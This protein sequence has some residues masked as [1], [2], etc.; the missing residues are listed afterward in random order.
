MSPEITEVFI[1]AAAV[2]KTFAQH[3]IHGLVGT[4]KPVVSVPVNLSNKKDS[5]E[6]ELLSE[7]SLYCT[8]FVHTMNWSDINPMGSIS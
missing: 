3:L 6:I 2:V 1:L 4:Q 7:R 5:V 8:I